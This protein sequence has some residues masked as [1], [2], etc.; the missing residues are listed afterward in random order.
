MSA[1]MRQTTAKA[2]CPDCGE[3]KVGV[4]EVVLRHN[5]D[6]DTWAY[7]FR[8]P[9]CDL[10][11]AFET[12]ARLADLMRGVGSP[13]EEWRYPQELRESH[14]G[15]AITSDDILELHELLD[16]PDWVE[17]LLAGGNG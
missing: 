17:H 9:E 1:G 5:L 2:S 4:G 3:V 16:Q 14:Y 6:D 10:I 11:A 8:C 7:R 12:R 13:V 15:P